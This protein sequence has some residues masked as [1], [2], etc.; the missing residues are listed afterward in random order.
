MEQLFT[1][2]SIA[3]FTGK[4]EQY[5]RKLIRNGDL[6]AIRTGRDWLI[7]YT[8]F[9]N[10]WLKREQ[11]PF[12]VC[13]KETSVSGENKKHQPVAL[14]FFS[15]AMGLDL[16]IEKAGFDIR[17]A[18]ESDKTCQ[19]TITLNRPEIPLIGDVLN[20]S[21]KDIRQLSGIQGDIDL[22]VGGPPCQAFSTA[23]A[24]RGFDD[25][26]GNVFLVYIDLL[27]KLRPKYIVIENVRGLLSAALHSLP[28]E[29]TQPWVAA[30]IGKPGGALLYIL[31]KLKNGGYT[32]SFNLYNTANYGVPQI[33]E[34]VVIICTRNGDKVPY[35]NPT[36]SDDSR[37]GL[38]KWV[39]FKDAVEGLTECHHSNFPEKRLKY[40]SMLKAGQYWKDLPK[41]IQ[42]E[43]MGNSF[44]L[45][46]GKTGFYRR[47]SWDRPSCT[48]VTSPT[49]PATDI[50][51]PCENRPLSIEEYKRIQTFPDDWKL[52]GNLQKQYKQVGNAVPVHMGEIIGKAILDHMSRK[53]KM[54]PKNFP[55][56]RYTG[57][58][59]ISW[60]QNTRK[61][62]SLVQGTL[63]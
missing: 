10:Y 36:H 51:H 56:S 43:A 21:E 15:G 40:Y 11:G 63:F 6:A 8:D 58:D 57:T 23:G 44:Y 7:Q 30:S 20:Y 55:F 24:R 22:V 49:M 42:P 60:E 47:L 33:R 31:E 27:L 16:G 2:P 45:G 59:D 13:E 38:P 61:R 17:L 18:C 3:E 26:R 32:T 35:L 4:S 9:K 25:A 37:F 29:K 12:P 52:A 50:C 5:I 62:L 1:V 41:E 19:Q 54:P 39:T 48:L 53:S 14:S 46:G 28:E 34:R